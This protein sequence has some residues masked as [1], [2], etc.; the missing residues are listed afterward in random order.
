MIK[1]LS[2]NALQLSS[3]NKMQPVHILC[4][5]FTTVQRGSLSKPMSQW[6]NAGSGGQQRGA[7][8]ARD[9]Y[10]HARDPSKQG[11]QSR[12]P[13]TCS[14]AARLNFSQE[15]PLSCTH[16]AAWPPPDGESLQLPSR[17]P[18]GESTSRHLK[19]LA[20]PPLELLPAQAP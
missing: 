12:Q 1:A 19:F 8:N 18:D 3:S 10:I 5:A 17:Q 15:S 6:G 14:F 16:G 4:T 11:P 13:T 20:G 9:S 7:H 2:H